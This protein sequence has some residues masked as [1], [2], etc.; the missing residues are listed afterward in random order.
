MKKIFTL[1]FAVGMLA[2]AQAQ[3]GG[4]RDSRQT[5]QRNT[6]QADQ[7]KNQQNDQRDFDKSYGGKVN[8]FDNNSYGNDGRYDSKYFSFDKGRNMQI[9]RINQKYDFKIQMVM[10]NFFMSWFEKKRQV[11]FLQMQRQMEISMV[12]KRGYDRRGGWDDHDDH[13]RDRW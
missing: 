1:L 3:Y 6:Q 12:Y 11:H 2:V 9:A 8:V 10:R 13:S 4:N 7:W 5:D